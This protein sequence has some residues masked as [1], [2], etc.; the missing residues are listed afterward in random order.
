MN[1]TLA[2]GP[3]DIASLRAELNELRRDIN[4]KSPGLI[5][6]QGGSVGNAADTTDDTLF[7][8]IIAA[9]EFATLFP[10]AQPYGLG[11]VRITAWGTSAAN[12]NNKTVKI[13]FGS[14]TAISTGVVTISAKTWVARAIILRTGVSTQ[15]VIGEAISD[16]TP[17]AASA[18]DHTQDETAAITV[19]VTGASPTTGAASDILGKGM[20]VEALR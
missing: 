14:L 20:T 1:L 11:G 4:S 7:A 18:Q 9:G 16:A 19:K 13:F 5:N 17:I 15:K 6:S 12:G 10:S 3:V 2:T 8:H